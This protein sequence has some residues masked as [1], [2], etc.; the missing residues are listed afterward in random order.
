MTASFDTVHAKSNSMKTAYLQISSY[1]Y[2]GHQ[3][4]AA[5]F[6]SNNNLFFRTLPNS[7]IHH[8]V[9]VN[10]GKLHSTKL[11]VALRDVVLLQIFLHT[12]LNSLAGK[13]IGV[14]ERKL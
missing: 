12:N 11:G 5:S 8:V 4:R 9:T 6:T 2:S 7:R 3:E 1:K 13:L 14:T 10:R